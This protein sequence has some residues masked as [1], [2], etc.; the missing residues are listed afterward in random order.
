[1]CDSHAWPCLRVFLADL[2]WFSPKG[3][4]LVQTTR[5]PPSSVSF[6]ASLS[7]CLPV[8]RI[9]IDEGLEPCPLLSPLLPFLTSPGKSV[10]K[11]KL[12]YQGSPTDLHSISSPCHFCTW[13]PCKS[14]TSSPHH[15]SPLSRI[16]EWLST[17]FQI[18]SRPL[19]P[20]LR[21]PR[22]APS[23][24]YLMA[25]WGH[26]TPC[27]DLSPLGS[28]SH[29]SRCCGPAGLWTPLVVTASFTPSHVLTQPVGRLLS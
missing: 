9:P 1:M 14:D 6:T 25:F 11:P 29:Q 16:L 22:T 15:H 27:S 26:A 17:A 13:T 5:E 2:C 18:N 21:P 7:S 8:T 19:S 4:A 3:A 23:Q 24:T 20:D 12:C 28:L 10:L